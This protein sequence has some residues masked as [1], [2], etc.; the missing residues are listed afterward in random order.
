MYITNKTIL[1]VSVTSQ[2]GGKGVFTSLLLET[3]QNNNVKYYHI[4]NQRTKSNNRFL[5]TIEHIWSFISYKFIFVGYLISRK[6]DIVQLHTSGGFDFID[7]SFFIVLSK[8]F[9]KK[10][11][12]RFGGDDFEFF[13]TSKK[14]LTQQYFKWII[15]IVDIWI[16]Q[17]E[18]WK[19]LFH[20]LTKKPQNKMF[21][22]PNFVNT[23][24]YNLDVNKF[25]RELEVLFIPGSDLMRKGYYDAII[26]IKDVA[27]KYRKINF[28][29]AGRIQDT[30]LQMFPNI[31]IYDYI[32]G[33]TKIGLFN[34]CQIFLLPTYAEG[35][36]NALVE[37][38]SSGMGIIT[39][40]IPQITCL[41]ED[42]VNSLF[43]NTNAPH[44]IHEKLLLLI[45]NRKMIEELGNAAKNTADEL[46]SIEHLPEYLKT[47]YQAV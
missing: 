2:T 27:V 20:N 30:E 1:I 35:F 17:S 13:F 4:N 11:I 6:I 24:L 23:K 29:I 19:S 34:K 37:A 43:I 8:I 33:D 22:L 38:M 46:Y 44:E 40:N 26:P 12:V 10:T 41:V 9:N 25:S 39:S 18:Y 16:V 14:S 36:P 45:E 3:L 21:I 32:T 42:G 28:H 31:H 7:Y 15:N 5:K 47:L